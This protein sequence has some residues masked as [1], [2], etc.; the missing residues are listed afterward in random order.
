MGKIFAIALLGTGVLGSAVARR[1]AERGW[2]VTVYNRTREKALALLPYGV[3]LSDHVTEAI[4]VAD[5]ILLTLADYPATRH[6][7][8]EAAQKLS[9][10]S[11]VIVQMGTISSEQ[12]RDLQDLVQ[13]HG[14][15]YA[16]APVLGS[17]PEA[18]AGRLL[19]F[20]GAESTLWQK[21]LPLFQD[22]AE[23]PMWVGPV[24]K[25]A[26][27]KLAFNQLI[28]TLTLAFATSLTLIERE[29]I[30]T[31]CFME[32]LRQSSLYAPT[33]DKKLPRMLHHHYEEP[34]FSYRHLVKDFRLFHEELKRHPLQSEWVSCLEPFFRRWENSSLANLDY[35]VLY[36]LIGSKEY[37]PG[38]NV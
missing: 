22:L 34:N 31:E 32:L 17:A 23:K 2:R 15:L 1:L 25:A 3:T 12:S 5:I 37:T 9:F 10:H 18:L 28:A 8:E 36:K 27:V 30:A 21:L 7:L 19:V 20:G 33:F 29:G 14:G 35:S 11:K 26:I 24:G 4:A 16:E 38:S 13:K 6:V